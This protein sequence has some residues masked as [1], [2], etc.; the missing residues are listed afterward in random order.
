[1]GQEQLGA[2]SLLSG[3]ACFV[4]VLVLVLVLGLVLVGVLV[5]VHVLL[6]LSGFSSTPFS[7]PAAADGLD[8]PPSDG[9]F[10][11]YADRCVASKIRLC[12]RCE[13]A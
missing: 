10:R 7:A 12:V 4:L 6:L 1:M 8:G 5:G 11:P 2:A 9:S 13:P 3:T